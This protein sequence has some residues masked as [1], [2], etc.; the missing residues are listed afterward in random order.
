MRA[1]GTDGEVAL[2]DAFSHEFAF[3]IHL[4]CVL[5]HR[6]NVKQQL[7]QRHF[8]ERHLKETLDEIF[9]SRKGTIYIEGLIDA[10][11]CE[12]FDEKLSSLQEIWEARES[13]CESCTRGFFK[14]FQ[15]NKSDVLKATAIRPIR[16]KAGLGSPPDVF[17]TNASESINSVIKSKVNYEK[18]E[19]NKFIDK[20]K[21]LVEDQQKEVERA[22]CKRGKYRFRPEYKFLEIDEGKWFNMTPEA[23]NKH[24]AKVNNTSLNASGG[25]T[26]ASTSASSASNVGQQESL[27]SAT[28]QSTGDHEITSSSIESSTSI[29]VNLD[30]LAGLSTPMAVLEGIWKKAAVLV[31]DPKKIA[32]APGC[33]SLARM[34]AS[35]TGTRPHLVLPGKGAKFMCDSECPNYKSFG[36]CSHVVAVAEVNNML[37][38]FIEYFIKQRKVPNMSR[39]A[40]AGMPKGCGRKGSEPP[41]KKKKAVTSE[42]RVSLQTSS[43]CSTP[44]RASNRPDT[45]QDTCTARVH[46]SSYLSSPSG[47]P[48]HPSA[49]PPLLQS[50]STLHHNRSRER[51]FKLHFICGNIS[52]CAGCKGKYTKPASPPHNLCVQHE[53]WRQ[54]TYPNSASPSTKFGNSYYH[55]DINCI[56]V[57]WPDFTSHQLVIPPGICAT[58]LPEHWT[59]LKHAFDINE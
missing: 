42:A 8:P 21:C 51:P 1:F 6:R 10:V 50:P 34:V 23:R 43:S 58:L 37:P 26:S 24:M 30:S 18:G 32:L 3:A 57:N 31:A 17:T 27:I 5:H 16:E 47:L 7:H 49:P 13:S 9:G 19:L 41:R 38:S 2:A 28:K 48:F 52:R 20:M 55:A 15:D 36:I 40:K 45:M 46:S 56:Q 54:M 29:S 33:S 44:P 39:L 22:V 59:Y 35:K 25:S 4:S 12:N 11:S 53:E 14:W